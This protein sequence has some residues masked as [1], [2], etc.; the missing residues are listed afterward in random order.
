MYNLQTININ[1][2]L[3]HQIL[4]RNS[5]ALYVNAFILS[6]NI[7]QNF[8]I[9]KIFDYYVLCKDFVLDSYKNHFSLNIRGTKTNKN[10]RVRNF[11]AT[12]LVLDLNDLDV[13]KNGHAT[14]INHLNVCLYCKIKAK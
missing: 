14:V 9:K 5:P 4:L 10:L 1:N 12:Q 8:E 11:T 13:L 2:L 3:L 6:K 7:C